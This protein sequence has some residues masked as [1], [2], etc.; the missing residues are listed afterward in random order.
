MLGMLFYAYKLYN[1]TQVLSNS[2]RHDSLLHK[3][4]L[5]VY[6][7]TGSLAVK[8]AGEIFFRKWLT[9]HN[10]RAACNAVAV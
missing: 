4:Q 7:S 10:Y 3:V 6:Y 1:E 5:P 2:R 9:V 8:K